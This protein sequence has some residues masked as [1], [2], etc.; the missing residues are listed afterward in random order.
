MISPTSPRE[1]PSGLTRTRVRSLSDTVGQPTD[2]TPQPSRRTSFTN[3]INC[4]TRHAC[5]GCETPEVDHVCEGARDPQ[6]ASSWPSLWTRLPRWP[7]VAN[8]SRMHDYEAQRAEHLECVTALAAQ[9]PAD[10]VISHESAALVYGF[11]TYAVPAAVRVTRTRGRVVR[12]SDVHV[13]RAELRPADRRLVRADHLQARVPGRPS[14]PVD[15]ADGATSHARHA[16]GGCAE[17]VG[18]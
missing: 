8:L 2:S 14:P 9:L 15:L 5:R 13:H 4:A 12:T 3:V 18:T 10:A 1:T 11:P 16:L 6:G 17:R 7:A